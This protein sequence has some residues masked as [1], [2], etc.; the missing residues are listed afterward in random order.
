MVISYKILKV[1]VKIWTPS[2]LDKI[3][4]ISLDFKIIT[5]SV[6]SFDKGLTVPL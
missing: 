6:F 1:V 4:V 5:G 3:T 2:C